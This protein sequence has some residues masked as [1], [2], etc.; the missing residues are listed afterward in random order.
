M[1]ALIWFIKLVSL[2]IWIIPPRMLTYKICTIINLENS[3][4]HR[5]WLPGLSVRLLCYCINVF[6]NVIFVVVVKKVKGWSRMPRKIQK[7]SNFLD[8]DACYCFFCLSRY[9]SLSLACLGAIN[10][11]VYVN[12]G[13]LLS[14]RQK[15][16]LLEVQQ[17]PKVHS[18]EEG[19]SGKGHAA[20]SWRSSLHC[21][22]V[23][24]HQW[25]R[26]RLVIAQL[27]FK[28]VTARKLGMFLRK[29]EPGA[30]YFEWKMLFFCLTDT[31]CV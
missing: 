23:L 22:H 6:F 21:L 8:H 27:A 20:F 12:E 17:E 26:P 24:I 13:S 2:H 11:S 3:G 5:L 30:S 4:Q 28:L 1:F 10:C 25:R 7:E 29:E 14:R 19:S 9:P 16:T 15:Y 18:C 31:I